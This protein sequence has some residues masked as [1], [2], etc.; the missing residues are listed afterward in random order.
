MAMGWLVVVTVV[1]CWPLPVAVCVWV[2]FDI[3]SDS[4]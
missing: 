3:D 2:N 4:G 1:V